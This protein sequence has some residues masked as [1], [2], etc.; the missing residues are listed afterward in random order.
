LQ[1]HLNELVGLD[2]EKLLDLRYDRYRV[3]G[4]HR[5]MAAK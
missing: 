2:T 1:K 3:L 4:E 5:E